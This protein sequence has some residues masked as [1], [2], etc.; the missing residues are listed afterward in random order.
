MTSTA[1]LRR[2]NGALY[3]SP[4]NMEASALEVHVLPLQAQQLAT[5][6]PRIEQRGKGGVEARFMLLGHA[7]QRRDVPGAPAIDSAGFSAYSAIH[8]AH[9][10]TDTRCRIE[11][12]KP[13]ALKKGQDSTQHREGVADRF[14][15]EP[16]VEL[17]TDELEEVRF[18]QLAQVARPEERD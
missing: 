13:V 12:D 6:K 10:L 4:A 15:S 2:R 18:S 11:R 7:Q 5:P 1:A 17:Y 16:C 9:Q 3:I 8:T 14:G